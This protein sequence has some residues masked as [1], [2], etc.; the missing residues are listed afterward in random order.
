MSIS[1]SLSNAS[2]DNEFILYSSAKDSD[3]FSSLSAQAITLIFVLSSF[4]PIIY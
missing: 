4:R 3:L 1:L 2:T